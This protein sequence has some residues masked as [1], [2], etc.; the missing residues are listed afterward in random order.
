MLH[1]SKPSPL[2]D[3]WV[4]KLL[5]F[6]D[7]TALDDAGVSVYQMISSHNDPLSICD[8]LKEWRYL[9][10]DESHNTYVT[11]LGHLCGVVVTNV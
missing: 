9:G 3:F 2:E 8:V 1:L 10:D 11:C 5:C 6:V 7:T 4:Y